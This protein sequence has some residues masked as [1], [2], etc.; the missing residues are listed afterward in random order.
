MNKIIALWAFSMLSLTTTPSFAMQQLKK[1]IFYAAV[2]TLVCTSAF[3][4]Y[5][6]TTTNSSQ[7]DI[8]TLTPALKHPN[9]RPQEYYQRRT[10]F[11]NLQTQFSDYKNRTGKYFPE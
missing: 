10:D 6:S 5:K 8:D 2:P 7:K 3:I 9:L 4:L 1:R 11:N